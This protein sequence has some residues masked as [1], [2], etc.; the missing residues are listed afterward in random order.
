VE[1]AAGEPRRAFFLALHD[2]WLPEL[3][4]RAVSL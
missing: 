3:Q 2:G 4:T 1:F